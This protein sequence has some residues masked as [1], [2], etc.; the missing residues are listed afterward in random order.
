MGIVPLLLA[1]RLVYAVFAHDG[2]HVI[3][4]IG[5]SKEL[6]RSQAAV[7]YRDG[8]RVGSVRAGAPREL[9]CVSSAADASIDGDKPAL[10]EVLIAT[11]F[12]ARERRRRDR[13]LTAGE[14]S[15]LESYARAF[16]REHGAKTAEPLD[17]NARVM[18]L[19]DELLVVG[20][21]STAESACEGSL[22]LIAR[23]DAGVVKPQVA[24]FRERADCEDAGFVEPLEHVDI[25]G[26]G[27]DEVI[28]RDH[29]KE[30]YD[31]VIFRR[32][33]GAWTVGRGGP[34]GC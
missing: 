23:V 6:P 19:G 21:W 11:N 25:D 10:G 34:T 9:A 13:E 20:S 7:L 22:F 14:A 28:A 1:S 27:F 8:V 12:V 26:D 17:I 5:T 31:Y 24:R 32:D 30:G 33:E 15:V 18:D 4:P 29:G 16:L 2:G 3:E